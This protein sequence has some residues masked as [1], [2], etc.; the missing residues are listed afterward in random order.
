[1]KI[2]ILAGGFGT[3][4]SEESH[5]IPKPMIEIGEK[6]II[7]H[8]MKGFSKYGYNEFIICLG[9]KSYSIKEFFADYFIH[10]SDVTFNL[11]TNETIIHNSY[12]EPWKVTLVDTG[13]NTMTGG[14]VKRIKPYVKNEPFILTYGDGVSDINIKELEEFHHA[15]GKIATLTAVNAKQRFGILGIDNDIVQSFREKSDSDGNMINGGFMVLNSEI[16]DYIENDETVFEK[17]PLET[18][19]SEGQ[20]MAFNHNGYWQ[21]MDTQRDKQQLEDLWNSGKAPWKLW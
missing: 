6:P 9:Y 13:L 1:M 2:V 15:H 21:C 17:A 4:I 8:I 16:F 19:A 10:T 20:L 11:A 18:L 5:L 3:R 12:S 14:R 7:W